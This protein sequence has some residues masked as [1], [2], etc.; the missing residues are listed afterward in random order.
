MVDF[1]ATLPVPSK[2]FFSQRPIQKQLKTKMESGVVQS[3]AQ[4]TS[5][6]W[7]F[8]IGWHIITQTQY[9]ALYEFF[10]A[11]IGTTFNWSHPITSTVYVVRFSKGELPPAKHGGH[12]A[13]VF[14]WTL[15]GLILEQA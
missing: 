14:G 12:V 1:P 15:S 10:T 2:Q 13:G 6:R 11:N 5:M 7:E 3:R 9:A 4:H 8:T